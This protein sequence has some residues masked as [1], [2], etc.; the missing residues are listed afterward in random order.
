MRIFALALVAAVVAVSIYCYWFGLKDA[1]SMY[2]R[3][4]KPVD[5]E[6]RDSK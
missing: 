3:S 2:P 1:I 5:D 4:K 6:A